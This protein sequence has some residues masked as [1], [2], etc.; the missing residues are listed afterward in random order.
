MYS[1]LYSRKSPEKGPLNFVEFNRTKEKPGTVKLVA[2]GRKTRSSFRLL[3]QS[4]CKKKFELVAGNLR[5]ALFVVFIVVKRSEKTIVIVSAINP[6][7]VLPKFLSIS[8][9]HYYL[10][11][12]YNV[13]ELFADN[14]ALSL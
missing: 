1:A 9:A 10:N 5:L 14:Y 2:L 11:C 7:A 3:R 12:Y 13:A 6:F 8:H 4:S